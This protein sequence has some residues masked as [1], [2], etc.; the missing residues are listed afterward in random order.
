VPGREQGGRPRLPGR[1]AAGGP[2]GHVQALL[3]QRPFDDREGRAGPA[4]GVGCRGEPG[5]PAEQPRLGLGADEQGYRPGAVGRACGQPDDPRAGFGYPPERGPI[6]GG[7]GCGVPAGDSAR[8]LDGEVG[9][10]GLRPGGGGWG[11]DGV[12]GAHADVLLDGSRR[13][14]AVRQPL[15]PGGEQDSG[16]AR[17]GGSPQRV[18]GAGRRARGQAQDPFG[19]GVRRGSRSREPWVAFRCG[20]AGARV[21]CRALAVKHDRAPR[22]PL[23]DRNHPVLLWLPD[24]QVDS[25]DSTMVWTPLVPASP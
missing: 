9:Q 18:G 22:P 8:E 1:P 13:S 24:R 3:A 11:S 4:V 23:S 14:V 19:L 10:P 17:A 7:W 21:P 20:M 25:G 16:P 6:P 15:E 2:D 5:W 12:E